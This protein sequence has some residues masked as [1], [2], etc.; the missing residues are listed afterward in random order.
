MQPASVRLRVQTCASV[1]LIEEHPVLW[2]LLSRFTVCVL[3][4]HLTHVE[5][6]FNVSRFQGRIQST[7][8][9]IQWW[10]CPGSSLFVVI[11]RV[12]VWVVF[13]GFRE[14]SCHMPILTSYHSLCRWEVYL[15]W[16]ICIVTAHLS[17][18][19]MRPLT[20]RN[21]ITFIF[22]SP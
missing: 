12:C 16:V 6:H 1:I 7:Q 18:R 17:A 21:T 20:P 9:S 4:Y 11:F 19:E 5:I 22:L 10:C 8:K 2:N 13:H 14:L 15:L 3:A